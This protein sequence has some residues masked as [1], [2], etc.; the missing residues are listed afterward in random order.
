[1]AKTVID[2]F[3]NMVDYQENMKLKNFN[4]KDFESS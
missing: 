1:M 3:K 2:H 4:S